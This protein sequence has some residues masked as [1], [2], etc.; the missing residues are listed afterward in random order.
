MELNL[1]DIAFYLSVVKAIVSFCGF[2]VSNS[3]E[4]IFFIIID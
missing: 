2:Y 4:P 1:R 3:L